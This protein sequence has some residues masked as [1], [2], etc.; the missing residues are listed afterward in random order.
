M[1]EPDKD[2]RL[3][4]EREIDQEENMYIKNRDNPDWPLAVKSRKLKKIPP[5]LISQRQIRGLRS[6]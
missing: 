5:H 6:G 2:D 1:T 3:T 4:P